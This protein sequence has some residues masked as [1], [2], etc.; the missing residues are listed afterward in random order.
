MNNDT[1][2]RPGGHKKIRPN[3]SINKRENPSVK[4]VKYSTFYNQRK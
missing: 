1:A 3:T 4:D 2:E